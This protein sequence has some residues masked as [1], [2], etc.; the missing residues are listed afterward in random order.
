MKKTLAWIPMLLGALVLHGFAEIPAQP[1]DEPAATSTKNVLASG[2]EEPA[3]VLHYT[4]GRSRKSARI[5]DCSGHRNDGMAVHS[6][7]RVPGIAKGQWAARFDGTG[8]YIRVPRSASLEPE[9]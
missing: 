1:A 4:F 5:K 6:L 9:A 3:P 7:R 2:A 8:D